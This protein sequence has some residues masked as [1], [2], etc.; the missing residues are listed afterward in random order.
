MVI[1]IAFIVFIS[2]VHSGVAH[3]F[4]HAKDLPLLLWGPFL[5]G[6]PVR[7]NMLNMP[8]SASVPIDAVR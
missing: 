3:Y 6:G 2:L 4:W 1:T 8:K 7:P 5:C